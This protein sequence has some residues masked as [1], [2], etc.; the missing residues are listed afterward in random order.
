MSAENTCANQGLTPGTSRFRRCVDAT[1]QSNR[2]QS[3]Q[4]A[5]ATAVGVGAAIVGGA[6]LGA[7]LDDNGGYYHGHHGYYHHHRHHW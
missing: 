6:L 3:Q 4:A 5:N 1:Y 7:A 2:E